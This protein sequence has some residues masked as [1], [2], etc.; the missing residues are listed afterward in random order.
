MTILI[1]ARS[2]YA[3]RYSALHLNSVFA[4]LKAFYSVKEPSEKT[5]DAVAPKRSLFTRLF[6]L[7]YTFER[8]LIRSRITSDSDLARILG[9][10]GSTAI[11][12]MATLSGLGTLGVDTSPIIAGLGI[13]GFAAGFALK[14]IATNFLSGLMLVFNRPF[15]RGQT[16]RVL[17]GNAQLHGVVESV[18]SRY[19]LLRSVDGSLVM[20][21]SVLVYS[22]SLLVESPTSSS[23]TK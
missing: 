4:H 7:S 15:Q 6:S 23:S 18:D 12:S 13:T 17:N 2:N 21:P 8:L 1:R 3:F 20:I 10:A 9:K 5:K 19:V 16:I 11:Y 14:E 22:N